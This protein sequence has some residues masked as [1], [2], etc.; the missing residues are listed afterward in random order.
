MRFEEN[1]VQGVL[2]AKVLD[3]R[4]VADVAPAFKSQLATY[5]NQNH[6]SI[7]LDL[8][9]VDFIDSSGLGALVATLK[10][11]GKERNLVV[12]SARGSV[13]SMFKLTRMDKVFRLYASS[14]DALAALA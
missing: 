6:R 9:S 2:V 11:M 4:I 13:A 1:E 8:S 14:E 7:V 5:L 10:F 12:S 3:G